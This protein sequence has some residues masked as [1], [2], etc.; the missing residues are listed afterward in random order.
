M[1]IAIVLGDIDGAAPMKFVFLWRFLRSDGRPAGENRPAAVE[2]RHCSASNE[3]IAPVRDASSSDRRTE[4]QSRPALPA[5]ESINLL[6]FFLRLAGANCS[7]Q[8]R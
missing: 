8:S 7:G 5:F 6:C 2:N 3:K 4:S 1:Q